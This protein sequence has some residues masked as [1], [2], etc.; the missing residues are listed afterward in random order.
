MIQPKTNC[1]TCGRE[2]T[3]ANFKKHYEAC[4]NPDS[5][6][7]LK[8]D[9]PT[10]DKSNLRC[11]FCKKLCKNLNSLAQH[12]CRCK[13]N[14][15]R[16]DFNKLG[17]YSSCINKG[18]NKYINPSIAKQSKTVIQKIH[19]GEISYVA[20]SRCKYKFGIYQ[21]IPCDSSW[22]LAF[23][24]Y[25]LDHDLDIQRNTKSFLYE[26]EGTTHNYFPDFIVNDTYFEIKGYPSSKDLVKIEQFRKSHKLVVID[27]SS[28][29]KYIDYCTYKYSKHFI[30]M[31]DRNHPSWMDLI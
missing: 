7:N 9:L 18:S 19:S 10:R 27:S 3:K 21:G 16:R 23:V 29:N 24:I 2:I 20:R 4:N 14:P 8:K 17:L 26:Y 1:P 5:K 6:L 30:E 13:E 22:E 11:S 12:E 28:I 25:C 15:Q 31:Y